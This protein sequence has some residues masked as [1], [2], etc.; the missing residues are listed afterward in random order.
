MGNQPSTE[1]PTAPICGTPL[2]YNNAVGTY[3]PTQIYIWTLWHKD[4]YPRRPCVEACIDDERCHLAPSATIS[5]TPVIYTIRRREY[6]EPSAGGT[7]GDAFYDICCDTLPDGASSAAR[8]DCIIEALEATLT[9]KNTS[10]AVIPQGT[11]VGPTW[12]FPENGT[13]NVTTYV[14]PTFTAA[15]GNDSRIIFTRDR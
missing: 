4:R 7:T 5:S 10:T 11:A 12:T 14:N 6:L 15:A 1:L 8:A 13:W 2:G 9:L 3:R